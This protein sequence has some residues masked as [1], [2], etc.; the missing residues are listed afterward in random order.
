VRSFGSK[1]FLA[2]SDETEL[3]ETLVELVAGWAGALRSY[4]EFNEFVKGGGDF[5]G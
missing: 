2:R 3:R 1:V 5:V 4:E